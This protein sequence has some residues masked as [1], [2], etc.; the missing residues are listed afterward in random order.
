MVR[1]AAAK[2][3]GD[4]QLWPQPAMAER[5]QR[6]SRFFLWT[7][8]YYVRSITCVVEREI[9]RPAMGNRKPQQLGRLQLA[10]LK[11]L[12]DKGTGSVTEVKQ[13][14]GR[15]SRLAYTTVAT[16]LRRMEADGLAD[17]VSHLLSRR[18]VDA[19]ELKRLERLIAER[20]KRS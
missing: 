20:K 11:V 10:I 3:T 18:D 7:P 14:L 16:V 9:E 8:D 2:G 12:W 13:G 17:M 5:P 4:K 6:F 19:E 1:G 15:G